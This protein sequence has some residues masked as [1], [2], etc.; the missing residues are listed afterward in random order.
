VVVGH[1]SCFFPPP[2]AYGFFGGVFFFTDGSFPTME[3]R[4]RYPVLLTYLPNIIVG[5]LRKRRGYEII[6][7]TTQWYR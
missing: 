3:G 2:L 7:E 5:T 1:F 6:H 4:M